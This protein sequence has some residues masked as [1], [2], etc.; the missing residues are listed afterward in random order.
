[1]AQP[2]VNNAPISDL[3]QDIYRNYILP[4]TQEENPI[5]NDSDINDNNI[6]NSFK[7]QE[8]KND[9]NDLLYRFET[10]N[11]YHIDD[12]FKDIIFYPKLSKTI[13]SA[14]HKSIMHIIELGNIDSNNL[15]NL[16]SNLNIDTENI[17]NLLNSFKDWY[18]NNI[19]I[20]D[21]IGVIEV[22]ANPTNNANID[23]LNRLINNN[24]FLLYNK[25]VKIE[26]INTDN[27]ENRNVKIIFKELSMIIS[28]YFYLTEILLKMLLDTEFNKNGGT[29]RIFNNFED[30]NSS[31]EKGLGELHNYNNTS[32]NE[33]NC[34]NNM[35][36]VNITNIMHDIILNN[37]YNL[38]ISLD[39]KLKTL[40]S[41]TSGFIIDNSEITRMNNL[42]SKLDDDKNKFV[43]Y[44]KTL[45]DKKTYTTENFNKNKRNFIIILVLTILLVASNL[46]TFLISRSDS[47]LLFQI[48]II[49]I[50]VIIITKF[51]YLLK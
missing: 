16:R 48:N 3:R 15:N 9:F 6:I 21:D 24:Y 2:S 20:D 12:Y 8:F 7:I 47:S 11:H 40:N 44:G 14:I 42:I 17:I 46:Y 34:I 10:T 39:E 18:Y 43:H 19:L 1:M 23:L 22:M 28:K 29:H 5:L 38:L 45:K 32:R 49:I 33:N 31:D 35:P 13:K 30:Y 41:L 50:V 36:P 27:P 37:I 4:L 26:L 25:I 51:Y